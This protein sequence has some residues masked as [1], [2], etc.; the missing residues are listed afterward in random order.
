M[1]SSETRIKKFIELVFK[2]YE[3]KK[4]NNNF[5]LSIS[6]IQQTCFSSEYLPRNH[7]DIYLFISSLMEKEILERVRNGVYVFNVEKAKVFP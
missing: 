2:A 6:E 5:V 1:I 7:A 3:K 4:N